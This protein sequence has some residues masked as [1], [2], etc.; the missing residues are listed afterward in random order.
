[1]RRREQHLAFGAAYDELERQVKNQPGAIL[2]ETTEGL[3]KV[4]GGAFDLRKI[5]VAAA[6]AVVEPDNGRIL[7]LGA[8]TNE[9][10]NAVRARRG[11]LTPFAKEVVA[12]SARERPVRSIGPKPGAHIPG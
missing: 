5:A 1:M 6:R 7:S 12:A 8:L 2:I 10:R 9:Q 4:E 3:L 11:Q